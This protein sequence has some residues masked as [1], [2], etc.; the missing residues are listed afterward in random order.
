MIYDSPFVIHG[1]EHTIGKLQ[2]LFKKK[3]ILN[4]QYGTDAFATTIY[5]INLI[6]KTL[7]FYHKPKKSDVRDLV[8]TDKLIFNADYLGVKIAFEAFRVDEY[9]EDGLSVFSIPIPDKLLWI[10]A[11]NHYR[12]RASDSLAGY[13]QLSIESYPEPF[14]CKLFD[15]SIAGFSILI[16]DPEISALMVPDAYFEHCKILLEQTGEGSVS[17]QV[18]SKFTFNSDDIKRTEKVGCKFTQITPAFEDIIHRY[19]GK[20]EREN[21]QRLIV[22]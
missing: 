4:V 10:E 2:I 3:C 16:D 5:D 22:G 11:R 18:R 17:F 21:R 20:I 13:C 7:V 14:K 19:M 9:K 8:R 15:I 6:D 12:I 1:T